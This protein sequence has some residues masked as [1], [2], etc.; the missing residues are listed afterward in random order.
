MKQTTPL[1][2]LFHKFIKDTETGKR[3][4]KNGTRITADSIQNYKSVLLNLERF[5][6]KEQ[7]DWRIC[8]VSKLT[9][10]EFATEK[11][12]WKKFYYAFT[13]Y[14]YSKGC[15]DNYVGTNIKILRTFFNYLKHE[16]D[17]PIGEFH[18]Q[19]HVLK[20]DIEVLVISPEQLKF[21]IHDS[22]FDKALPEHLRQIKDIFVFGC[23]TGLR[24]SDIFLLSN[25][26]FENK[27]VDSYLKVKSKKTKT[28][29]A[30]KLPAYAVETYKKYKSK[31]NQVLLFKPIS[32]SNFNKHLK[33][34]GKLAG[35]DAPL[36]Q[37]REKRGKV[38][39][40]RSGRPVPFY[41]KMSS[42]MMRRTAITTLLILG[43]PEHL[44]R[45][46]SGHSPTSN[47][48]ARYVHY[49]QSYMDQEIDKVHRLLN[50]YE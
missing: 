38:S 4:K 7:F 50:T 19:F 25:K 22:I 27:R 46:I 24:F 31:S 2:P 33:T 41:H 29:T 17:I 44:V 16:K 15:H 42:H 48:F 23:T 11:N 3:L 40:S 34:I 26:N 39:K 20:E 6:A 8:D 37:L 5:I 35:F 32:L 43:M 21:L 13:E 12:Y 30:I 36:E 28:Y 49:A 1:L 45:K 47:S 14:L 18:K 9:K 10:R